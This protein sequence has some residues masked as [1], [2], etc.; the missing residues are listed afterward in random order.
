MLF[1][2]WN[3]NDS[4]RTRT[5]ESCLFEQLGNMPDLVNAAKIDH[6]NSESDV[7]VFV[8]E[9]SIFCN[10]FWQSQLG[11]IMMM[12]TK[13]SGGPIRQRGVQGVTDPVF[14]CEPSAR[15]QAG[16][17]FLI[18][19]NNEPGE[20]GGQG[21]LGSC[22]QCSVQRKKTINLASLHSLVYWNEDQQNRT[23]K[24]AFI[25]SIIVKEGF[26]SICFCNVYSLWCTLQCVQYRGVSCGW[27][28]AHN[29]LCIVTSGWASV[30]GMTRMGAE[31]GQTPGE[32]T[33]SASS[34]S[35]S[36][37]SSTR[38]SSV[39]HSVLVSLVSVILI[40]SLPT[41][42]LSHKQCSH[43]YPRDDQVSSLQYSCH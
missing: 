35:S 37:A 3:I 14:N 4:G 20:G 16:A 6:W 9:S 43:Y 13:P 24:D 36:V 40:S 7:Q 26:L 34:S 30:A 11:E 5:Q 12:M 38:S 1:S 17:W 19:A 39:I 8:A 41:Q 29:R 23:H 28:G 21:L 18:V 15:A 31:T 42:V 32:D 33:I 25:K 27:A 2:S 22:V 10:Y